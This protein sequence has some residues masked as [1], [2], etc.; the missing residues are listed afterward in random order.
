MY[1]NCFLKYLDTK[2]KKGA[3]VKIVNEG[4][5]CYQVQ[6]CMQISLNNSKLKQERT[7]RTHNFLGLTNRK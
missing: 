1:E 7:G 2:K 3:A 4:G 6:G 5:C